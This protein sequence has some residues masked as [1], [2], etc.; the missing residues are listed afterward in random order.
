M[1]PTRRFFLLTPPALQAQQPP[2]PPP[3]PWSVPEIQTPPFTYPAELDAIPVRFWGSVCYRPQPNLET[4]EAVDIPGALIP[5][6]TLRFARFSI[7]TSL[8]DPNNPHGQMPAA[9]VHRNLEMLVHTEPLRTRDNT[10]IPRLWEFYVI[11]APLDP[12]GK[13]WNDKLLLSLLIDRRGRILHGSDPR[14]GFSLFDVYP[15]EKKPGYLQVR[16]GYRDNI[17]THRYTLAIG[18]LTPEK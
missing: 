14:Q 6:P 13:R 7:W 10:L 15:V 17:Q 11:T 3:F 4:C 5:Q 2:T 8:Q 12:N 16:I 9:A 1:T 18:R